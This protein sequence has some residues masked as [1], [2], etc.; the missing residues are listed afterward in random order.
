[1]VWGLTQTRAT[2]PR[3]LIVA[4][5]ATRPTTL[6]IWSATETAG[7]MALRKK[8]RNGGIN[9]ESTPSMHMYIGKMS[10]HMRR[11]GYSQLLPQREVTRWTN[12]CDGNNPDH[13]KWPFSECERTYETASECAHHVHQ[14][15]HKSA[16]STLIKKN[17]LSNSLPVFSRKLSWIVL[18]I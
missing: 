3:G 15:K 14:E 13:F 1:M 9:N 2:S 6:A 7:T 10:A 12:T 11:G 4:T 8:W 18:S 16:W 17:T 5:V